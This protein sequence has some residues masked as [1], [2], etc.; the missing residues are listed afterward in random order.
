MILDSYLSKSTTIGRGLAFVAN[1]VYGLLTLLEG[2]GIIL[3]RGTDTRQTTYEKCKTKK[4]RVLFYPEGTRQKYTS[5]AGVDEL[6]SYL[7]FGLLKSIYEDGA[8]PV[9]LLISNNKELALNEKKFTVA[10]N[11]EINTRL[12]KPIHPA[13]FA[14]EGEFFDEIARVWY[15]CYVSTHTKKNE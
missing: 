10:F 2:R 1:S 7:K 3:Y 9:Q 12:S 8:N 6:K 13:D 5:L 11:V 14:T 4:G 15:D